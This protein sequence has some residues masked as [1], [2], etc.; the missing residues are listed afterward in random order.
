MPRWLERDPVTNSH[1]EGNSI[2]ASTQLTTP[3]TKFLIPG[4]VEES[5]HINLE[6]QKD[7]WVTLTK[8]SEHLMM[9]MLMA[10][11]LHLATQEITFGH[12]LQQEMGKITVLASHQEML[13]LCLST[14]TTFVKLAYVIVTALL[15]PTIHSGMVR[16]VLAPVPAVNSTT[17]H[18]SVSS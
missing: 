15:L 1:V 9:H 13:P 6:L 14:G 16:A 7:F 2:L 17:L 18:G 5:L 4:C 10:F 11:R 3:P 8:I 12:L